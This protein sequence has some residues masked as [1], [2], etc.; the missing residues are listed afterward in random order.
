MI[1][2]KRHKVLIALVLL[3]GFGFCKSSKGQLISAE[4]RIRE[5]LG[6]DAE[7]SVNPGETLI[8][9]L[10]TNNQSAR[11][12]RKSRGFIVLNVE[13]GKIIYEGRIEAGYVKWFDD[14]HLEMFSPPG[15]IRQGQD[16]NEL[17]KILNV[18]T[19]LV[20]SKLEFLNNE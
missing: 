12:P 16:K 6:T 17:I 9:G 14:E 8:L 1:S 18:D 5:A 3:T 20:V 19:K 10:A 4:Q 13:S 2:V 15:I 7:I 11:S